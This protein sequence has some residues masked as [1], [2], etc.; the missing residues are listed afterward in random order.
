[1]IVV[2]IRSHT[3]LDSFGTEWGRLGSIVTIASENCG[4]AFEVFRKDIIEFSA[5][6]GARAEIR[7]LYPFLNEKK[8]GRLVSRWVQKIRKS[9]ARLQDDL[10]S[11]LNSEFTEIISFD[12]CLFIWIK[13]KSIPFEMLLEHENLLTKDLAKAG[14]PALVIAS[15]PWDFVAITTFDM[16]LENG[17][18]AP[19]LRLSCPPQSVAQAKKTVSVVNSFLR[20]LENASLRQG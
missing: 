11:I 1:M 3:K 5:A 6:F 2:L 18:K 9:N 15:F 14:I 8:H 13:L 10:G 16:A 7:S 12:H 17:G 4:G 20:K 19:V